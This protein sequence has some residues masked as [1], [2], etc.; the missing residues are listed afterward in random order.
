MTARWYIVHAYSGFEKKVAQ[1]IRE[2]AA[3]NGL[4]E[5]ITEVFVP[6]EQVT[7]LRKGKKIS[8]ERKYFPGYVLVKMELSDATWHLVKNLP[9]VTGFLGGGGKGRP[10]PIADR[11]AEAIFAQVQ[12]GGEKPKRQVSFEIG[13]SV[14]INEGPFEGFN[15]TVEEVDA[16]RS[17]VKVSVSIFGRPTPVDLD[18][19]QVEKVA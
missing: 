1:D 19:T 8:A 2:K 9:K 5:K 3:Q 12:E 10:V 7:E 6:V 13:E 4:S 17:R 14:K 15:G 11:E 18:F 16:D